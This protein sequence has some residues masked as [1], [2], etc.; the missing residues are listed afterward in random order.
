MDQE[1]VFVGYEKNNGKLQALRNL[2]RKGVMPPVLIFVQS[3]ERAE[4]LFREL[5][6]ENFKV[7]AIHSDKTQEQVIF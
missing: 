4:Q 7:D 1:L 3:K 2:V 5:L 6:F